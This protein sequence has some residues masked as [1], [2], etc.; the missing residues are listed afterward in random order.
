MGILFL[1]INVFYVSL[2]KLTGSAGYY[3]LVALQQFY[4]KDCNNCSLQN[5][6]H[7]NQPQTIPSIII[8][9]YSPYQLCKSILSEVNTTQNAPK[10]TNNNNEN[11]TKKKCK[12]SD[13]VIRLLLFSLFLLQFL[14]YSGNIVL[15]MTLQWARTNL[16]RSYV[17]EN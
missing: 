4:S 9:Q 12:I 3:F 1:H 10:L 17:I 7:T 2:T 15:H 6:F 16:N 13:F 8:N 5:Q 14:K 11:P